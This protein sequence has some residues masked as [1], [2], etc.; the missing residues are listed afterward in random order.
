MKE[1]ESEQEACSKSLDS[2]VIGVTW[3]LKQYSDI[4]L[5]VLGLELE[6]KGEATEEED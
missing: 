2:S 5:L 1:E 3:A 4:K 6:R